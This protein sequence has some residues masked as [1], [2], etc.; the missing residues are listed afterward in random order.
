MLLEINFLWTSFVAEEVSA[1]QVARLDAH[2]DFDRCLFQFAFEQSRISCLWMA[3]KS[4][5]S[6][7]V[8]SSCSCY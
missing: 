8:R 7:K 5:S 6:Q 4:L 3:S 1:S 2:A